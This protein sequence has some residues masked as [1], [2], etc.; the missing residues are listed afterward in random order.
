MKITVFCVHLLVYVLTSC[1][2]QESLNID[3]NFE[4]ARRL[5][6]IYVEDQRYRGMIDSVLER[7][8]FESKE[9]ADF[10]LRMGKSDSSNLAYVVSIL[11]SNGWLGPEVVGKNGN[12][13]LF[14]VIQHADLKVQEKYLPIMRKAVKEGKARSSDLALL[15]DRVA[16]SQGKKQIYG[17]Q[18][19]LDTKTGKYFVPP[20]EDEINVNKRRKDIGLGPIEEYVKQFGIKY[21]PPK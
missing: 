4:L 14:L 8:G 6:S 15:E 2:G 11:D 1:N 5:D 7:Y 16:L 20:I 17:T 12:A 13:A 3:L 18:V 19:E 10:C 9:T 21:V